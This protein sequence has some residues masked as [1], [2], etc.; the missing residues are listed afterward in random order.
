MEEKK[1]LT[2]KERIHQVVGGMSDKKPNIIEQEI[3]DLVERI[4]HPN[5]YCP[6]CDEKMFYEVDQR[7]YKC[8]N[9][10][11]NSA[12][13]TATPAR[14]TPVVPKAIESIIEAAEAP[15]REPAIAKKAESIQKLADKARGGGTSAPTAEDEAQIRS[16]DPNAK[17]RINWS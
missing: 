16:S 17:G 13:T 8:I 7:I 12:S 9:C 1:K 4:T 11:Y 10:G 6:N 5:Y 15:I 3:F 14:G 2:L